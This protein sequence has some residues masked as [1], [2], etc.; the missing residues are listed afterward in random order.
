MIDF[1]AQAYSR[2]TSLYSRLLTFRSTIAPITE[3][4]FK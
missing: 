2:S 1:F 3:T 4:S